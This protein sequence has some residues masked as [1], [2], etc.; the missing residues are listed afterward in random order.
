MVTDVAQLRRYLNDIPQLM[1]EAEHYITPGT[2]PHD[3]DARHTTTIYKI[4]IV[5]EIVDLL[6]KRE[7]DIEDV[8]DIRFSGE[9]RLGVLPTLGLWV[10]LAYSE[11]EDLG[12]DPRI[13]CPERNHTTTGETSWLSEYAESIIDLHPCCEQCERGKRGCGCGCFHHEIET[14]WKELRQACRVRREYTPR[15]PQCRNLLQGVYGTPEDKAPAWWRCNACGFTAIA[16]AEIKRLAALQPRMTLRQIA[17]LLKLP[18]STLRGWRDQKRFQP[19]SHGKY[20]L[21]HVK[22]AAQRV[23]RCAEDAIA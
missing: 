12:H 7:K 5:A 22:L 16:D 20:E 2:A 6:D 18:I 10:A 11:L 19:D 23:G 17:D 3:P 1:A 14:I 13:C 4:P 15:C 9:R 21:E 8:T